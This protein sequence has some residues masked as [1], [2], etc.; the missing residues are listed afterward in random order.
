MQRYPSFLS[1]H[2]FRGVRDAAS[3]YL[4]VSRNARCFENRC[5]AT[6]HATRSDL[7]PPSFAYRRPLGSFRQLTSW[8][9]YV[10]LPGLDRLASPRN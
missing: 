9:S 5:C 1:L 3:I 7:S 10:L 2:A 8:W 4:E 6:A